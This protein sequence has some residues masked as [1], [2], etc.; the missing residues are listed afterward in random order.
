MG[1][2]GQALE[3]P[4]SPGRATH[5][6]SPSLAA[7]LN[8]RGT[9]YSSFFFDP[10]VS[11]QPGYGGLPGVPES[12]WKLTGAR[13]LDTP[14][15]QGGLWGPHLVIA[16]IESLNWASP[17]SAG[18]GN[19]WTLDPKCEKMFD[20]GNFRRKRKRRGEAGAAAPAGTGNPAVA[21]DP[22]ASPSPPTPEAAA[23]FSSFASTMGVLAGG[24][25]AFPGDL[26]GDFSLGKTWN[27]AA[28]L[29]RTH[30]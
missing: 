5:F 21:P 17:F 9:G 14:G 20:N 13:A 18:K 19:Y 16:A 26:E 23:C 30:P 29:P 8:L 25:A 3:P 1:F 10:A 28:H 27:Q 6:C 11:S 24:F 2:S 22:Q 4:W 12:P 7:G 15:G